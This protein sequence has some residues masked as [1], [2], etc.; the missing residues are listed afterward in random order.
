M[1]IISSQKQPELVLTFNWDGTVE[2]EAIGFQGKGCTAMTD[3]IEKALGARNEK[4][5][6]KPEYLRQ[7]PPN[8]NKRLIA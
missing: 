1:N 7:E 6:F 3:F 8:Q 4:K 2:K 5:R